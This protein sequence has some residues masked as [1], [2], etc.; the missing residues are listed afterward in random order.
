MGSKTSVDHRKKHTQKRKNYFSAKIDY[1]I[2][3]WIH[4]HS[5][6]VLSAVVDLHF[7]ERRQPC[8]YTDLL[9]FSK[10]K[11]VHLSVSVCLL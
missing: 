11:N 10:S 5:A 8:D 1:V 2:N 3:K 7:L 9:F 4:L 6:R